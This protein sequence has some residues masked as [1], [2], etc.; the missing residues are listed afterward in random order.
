MEEEIKVAKKKT[1]WDENDILKAFLEVADDAS[2]WV[3]EV[4]TIEPDKIDITYYESL[5][6]V[7]GCA[8]LVKKLLEV[9]DVSH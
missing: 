4:G 2:S 6:E 1:W 5:G 9:D 3:S 7:A 8:R